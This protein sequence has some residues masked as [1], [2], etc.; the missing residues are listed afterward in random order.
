MLLALRSLWEAVSGAATTEESSGGFWPARLILNLREANTRKSAIVYLRG[1]F[2]RAKAGDITAT[3]GASSVAAVQNAS[4]KASTLHA[5]GMR[6]L[7]SAQGTLRS[8]L[9]AARANAGASN[10]V[11]TAGLNAEGVLGISEDELTL[12]MLSAA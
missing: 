5:S 8:P 12:L 2:A 9:A 7:P 4:A 10:E 3:G 6:C 1:L 11:R